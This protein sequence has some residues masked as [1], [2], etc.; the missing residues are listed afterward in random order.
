MAKYIDMYHLWTF[1]RRYMYKAVT[2][3]NE[4]VNQV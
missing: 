2:T 4:S 1:P 3:G